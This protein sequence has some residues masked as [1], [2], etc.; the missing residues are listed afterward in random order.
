MSRRLAVSMLAGVTL[1]AG[2]GSSSSSSK[3]SAR[4][5]ERLLEGKGTE[6]VICTPGSD[7]WDYTCRSSGRKIGV[8]VDTGGPIE[9]SN[10]VPD[11]EPLQV[12]PGGEGPAVHARFVDEASSVCKELASM[13]TRLP[14][15][16]S[17]VDALSRMDQVLDL[18][19]QELMK[20]EAIKPPVAL[21]PE[22]TMMLG[23]LGQVVNDEMELRDGIATRQASTRQYALKSRARDAGQ[24]HDIALRVGL[25]ACSDPAIP[26][27][28]IAPR[29]H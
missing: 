19:R 27:P 6:N 2:C 17:R 24:A 4:D 25:P 28:G 12:G 8:D 21:L 29:P 18:R 22:Y 16:V 20:L 9:L 11:E 10:W 23:A 14:P 3:L 7:G 26:L 5:M 13:I 15:P 1:L